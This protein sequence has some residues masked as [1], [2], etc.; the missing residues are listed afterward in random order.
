M[1]KY[2][3]M[4]PQNIIGFIFSLF[5]KSREMY[6]DCIICW[7]NLPIGVSLGKYIILWD[8]LGSFGNK[9]KELS[10]RHE[11]GNYLQGIYFGPL[12][13]IIIGIPSAF[14]NI[15]SRFNPLFGEGY[16]KRYPENWADK[17][18]GIVR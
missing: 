15:I 8:K 18:S 3:W 2:I 9:Q 4:L 5:S 1:I 12:Y 17:L 13:L 16:Y 7:V 14:F 10:I 11:Y 6:N